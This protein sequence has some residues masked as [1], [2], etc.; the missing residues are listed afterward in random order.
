[1]IEFSPA[2]TKSNGWAAGIRVY[3]GVII[4]DCVAIFTLN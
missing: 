1:M 3:F 2:S 4:G